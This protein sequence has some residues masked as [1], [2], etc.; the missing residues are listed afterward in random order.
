[1]KNPEFDPA[2]IQVE[3]QRPGQPG[4]WQARNRGLL[5]RVIAGGND[6]SWIADALSPP[7]QIKVPS[8]RGAG[9]SID[10]PLK[11]KARVGMPAP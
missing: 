11:T 2:A 4:A 1:M 9:Y 6:F 7:T 3:D 5:R 10:L 8:F